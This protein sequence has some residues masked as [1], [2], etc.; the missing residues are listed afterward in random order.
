MARRP[1]FLLL[2]LLF[3]GIALPAGL[4]AQMESGDRGIPPI[5]SSGTLEV[6][7]IHVDVTGEDAQAARFA[8]WRMA[9]RKGFAALWAKT[10]NRPIAQAPNLSDSV[11][12][13]LVSSIVIEREQIGPNRYVADLGILFD[14]GRAAQLLGVGTEVRRSVPMLLIPVMV[15]AGTDMSVEIRN[16]WQ[17]AWAEFRAAQSP[18]NYVR[19][20][21]IGVDQLLV[22]SSQTHRPGRG[23]WTPS[24]RRCF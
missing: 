21:G 6:T 8:G 19:P 2:L 12:D 4:L 24:R 16:P 9:Q 15:T 20:S 22:N 3:V 18:I 23:W 17:R 7:G 10:H 14:R 11:L 13:T 5:D 1:G